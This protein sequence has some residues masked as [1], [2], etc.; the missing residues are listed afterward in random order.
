MDSESQQASYELHARRFFESYR[1]AFERQDAEA[2]ADHFA[3]PAH[4]ASDAGQVMLS[5]IL[6]KRE[7]TSQI[8]QLLQMYQRIDFQAPRIL[9]I[10]VTELSSRLMQARVHWGLDDSH[11]ARLYDF[12]AIYTLGCFA[13]NWKIVAIAHNELARYWACLEARRTPAV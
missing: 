2:I 9:A 11:G 10:S 12:D 6:S 7:W 1:A 13:G 4:V 3:Y 5:P 8:Q